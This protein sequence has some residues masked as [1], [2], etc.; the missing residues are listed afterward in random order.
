MWKQRNIFLK[1]KT[2][3]IN[4]L[5]LAPLIYSSNTINTLD[6]VIAQVNNIIQFF[7]WD[8]K[9]PKIAQ[10]TLIQTIEHGGLK[11]C[12]LE[13]KTEALKMVWKKRLIHPAEANYHNS[14]TKVKNLSTFFSANHKLLSKQ[15]IPFFL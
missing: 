6:K 9:T 1:R 11:L 7:L 2:T 12:H 4:T 8:G 13:T 10:S 5:A 15:N 3:I 14:S